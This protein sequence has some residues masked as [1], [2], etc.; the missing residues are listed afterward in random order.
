MTMLMYV[1]TSLMV[2]MVVAAMWSKAEPN[3]TLFQN[4]WLVGVKRSNADGA[5]GAAGAAGNG[6]GTIASAVLENQATQRRWLVKATVFIDA[7]G[8]GRL[9]AEAGAEWIQ[10][11][12][13]YA[14]YNESLAK[15]GFYR[16]AND[17]PDHETE[18]TSIDYEAEAKPEATTYMPPFWAGRNPP[19]ATESLRENTDGAPMEAPH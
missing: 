13:G 17:G 2:S 6:V 12:E 15:L 10:G 8:D 19:G 4:T 16:T 3:L 7:T 5:D 1:H 11:R 14:A 9:G 18:G